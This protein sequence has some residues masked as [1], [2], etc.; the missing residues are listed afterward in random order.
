MAGR[1][2]PFTT[3]I[4]DEAD[5]FIPQESTDEA[6]GDVRDLCVTLARR[7]RKFGLG[8]GISTQRVT[9]LDTEVMGNLHTYFVSKL[10]RQFDRQRVSEAFGIG[11]EQLSPTFTFRPGNWLI[12]SHDATGLRGVPIPASAADAV[13]R[14]LGKSKA[15]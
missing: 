1:R 12:I 2:E 8:I 3:F 15:G 4:F 9:L 11:E 13:M 5:L 6:T 14:I 10:P 7:G